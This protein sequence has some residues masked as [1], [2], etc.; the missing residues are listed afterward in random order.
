MAAPRHQDLFAGATYPRPA[1]FDEAD[2]ADKPSLIRDLP[3]LAPWQLEAIDNIYRRRLRPL[4]SVD[5]LVDRVFAVLRATGDL[6]NTYA[7]FCPATGDPLEEPFQ[8][9]VNNPA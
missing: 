5:D 9:L 2:V 6:D 4:Q 3:Q 8:P 1:S 7:L